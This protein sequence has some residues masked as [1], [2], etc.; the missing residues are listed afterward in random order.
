MMLKG[1]HILVTGAARGLGER[2]AVRL[3]ARARI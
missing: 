2:I 3:A 1:R